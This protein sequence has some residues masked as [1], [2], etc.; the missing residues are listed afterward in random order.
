MS[1]D[2]KQV[3]TWRIILAAILDFI[4]A[5]AIGG[6]IVAKFTGNTTEGGF[7]L[8]GMPALI[9]FALIIVYFVGARYVGG[10]IWQRLLKARRK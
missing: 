1:E 3:S 5:F 7:S 4:T 9:A 6:Y 8:D 10:T 2:V